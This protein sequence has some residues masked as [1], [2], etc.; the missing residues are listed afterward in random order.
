MYQHNGFGSRLHSKTFIDS[1]QVLLYS[2]MTDTKR[3]SDLLVG[4]SL[5]QPRQHRLFPC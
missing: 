5:L 1:L 4:L 3:Q 2:P